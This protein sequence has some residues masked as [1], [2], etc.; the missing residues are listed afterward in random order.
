M[1]HPQPLT[2]GHSSTQHRYYSS[3]ALPPPPSPPL[4]S[5]DLELALGIH[6]P[7]N[8]KPPPVPPKSDRPSTP[9]KSLNTVYQQPNFS[10][11]PKSN[12]DTP[13]LSH[14]WSDSSVEGE[15]DHLFNSNLEASY[16]H[17]NNC[18][19]NEVITPKNAENSTVILSD[20]PSIEVSPPI[21]ASLLYS[22]TYSDL[23]LRRLARKAH[24]QAATESTLPLNH[25]H[26]ELNQRVR[27]SLHDQ[28][29]QQHHHHQSDQ[30][31][32]TKQGLS[33]GIG[34]SLSRINQVSAS[35]T[36]LPVQLQSDLMGNKFAKLRSKNL[37]EFSTNSNHHEDIPKGY[38]HESRN[39]STNLEKAKSH[40]PGTRNLPRPSPSSRT[41]V[42]KAPPL[43]RK[44]SSRRHIIPLPKK[45]SKPDSNSSA[46]TSF[47]SSG[48]TTRAPTIFTPPS[49]ETLVLQSESALNLPTQTQ[50][51]SRD[52]SIPEIKLHPCQL[53]SD[54][55]HSSQNEIFTINSSD[56]AWPLA[57]AKL[58]PAPEIIE[59]IIIPGLPINSLHFDCYHDHRYLRKTRNQMCPV[60]CMMCHKKD[61]EIRWTCTWCCLSACADCTRSLT[62]TPN[63]NLRVC[64]EKL[65]SLSDE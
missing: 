28:N 55:P 37:G 26:L 62:Q 48:S 65:E 60:G 52:G 32:K 12:E 35:T 43:P 57:V 33:A 30:D 49:S 47:P 24:E 2:Q 5:P 51:D 16:D 11:P 22:S 9:S 63:R 19:C 31:Q 15:T 25:L 18:N 45:F 36:D 53:K 58:A 61:T 64:L 14:S 27:N 29:Q 54:I 56:Q 17:I 46:H 38:V 6:N 10:Q 41:Y 59:R 3:K 1:S 7:E 42:E 8:G 44:S 50:P 34:I 40:I 4:S 23:W 21:E 39:K 20:S 13:G